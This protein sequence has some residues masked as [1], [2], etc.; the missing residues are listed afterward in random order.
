MARWSPA[1]AAGFF[2]FV[3]APTVGTAGVI[4]EGFLRSPADRSEFLLWF[5]AFLMGLPIPSVAEWLQNKAS[6]K[7]GDPVGGKGK[8]E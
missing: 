7:P 8:E 3:V 5:F 2:R 6:S 1:Q 4:N